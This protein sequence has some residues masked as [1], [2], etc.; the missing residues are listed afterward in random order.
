MARDPGIRVIGRSMHHDKHIRKS[1]LEAADY[2]TKSGSSEDLICAV[3][4]AE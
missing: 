3:L 2:F 1:M 4:G